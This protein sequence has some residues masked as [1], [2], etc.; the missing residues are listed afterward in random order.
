MRSCLRPLENWI[1]EDLIRTYTQ[2]HCEGWAHCAEVWHGEEL[3]GGAYGI[4]LGSCFC[5]E[6]MFHRE[7]N[8]SKVALW[9]LVE[10]CRELGFTVFDAQIMNPHLKSL[11][12]Y[13]VSHEEYMELLQDAL[14]RKTVWSAQPLP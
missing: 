6:S 4:A 12:A 10:K 8:A 5:G 3:V 13:E 7:T 1:N 2:I 14:K 11:G 9:A